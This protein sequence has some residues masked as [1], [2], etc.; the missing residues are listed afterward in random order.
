MVTLDMYLYQDGYLEYVKGV[1]FMIE[2]SLFQSLIEDK[3]HYYDWFN[4]MLIRI[5]I[6]YVQ[7]VGKRKYI[8]K[9]ILIWYKKS[10]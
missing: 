10:V 1:E 8:F 6:Y 2:L 5:H 3:K 4:N 9:K 7:M